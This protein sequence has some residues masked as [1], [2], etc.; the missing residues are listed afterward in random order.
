M[1]LLPP[2]SFA[3]RVM[4]A[5]DSLGH[6]MDAALTV[7]AFFGVGFLLDRWLG[8]TPWLMIA[9]SMVA[10]VGVFLA[11][12]ARYTARMEQ[13]EN[14]FHDQRGHRQAAASSETISS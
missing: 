11:W 9:C 2:P 13:L 4:R 1:K 5:D 14:A 3:R 6:G 12:K 10:A 7:L 8:T